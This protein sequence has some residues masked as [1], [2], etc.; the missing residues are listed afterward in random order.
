MA[1]HAPESALPLRL[2]RVVL[3][4]GGLALL[5]F[6]TLYRLGEP[7]V[8]DPN[9]GRLALGLAAIALAGLLATSAWV[10]D[11][12]LA[13]LYGFFA[14]V[15]GWQL[16]QA[17][18]S[19]LSGISALG[20]VLVFFGCSAG[21]QSV[22]WM[23][24]YTVTFVSAAAFVAARVEDPA[25]P[26]L[27]FVATL[28][29]M[30]AL[31]SYVLRARLQTLDALAEARE[32]ALATARAKSEF[33]ATM[34]H[35]IRTPMNGVIGMAALLSRSRLTP[36]QEEFVRTIQSSSEAL[37]LII[38]DVLDFSMIEA[39]RVALETE[40]IALRTFLEDTIDIIA[41]SAAGKGIELVHRIGPDV[42]GVVVGDPAR[43]RQI[44]LNLLSNAVKFTP[45]GSVVLDVDARSLGPAHTAHVELHVRVTDTGIGIRPE[46][47]ETLFH[48]FAQGDAATTRRFGGTGL[49]LAISKRLAEIMGGRMWVESERGSGSTFHFTARLGAPKA[50]ME[51]PRPSRP[52]VVLV[53]DDHEASRASIAALVEEAGFATVSAA[54]PAEALEWV[55][56]GGRPVAV[57]VDQDLGDASG[58]DL[59]QRLRAPLGPAPILLLSS[60][61]SA[62]ADP[63]R[64]DA[65]LSKPVHSARFWDT[66]LRLVDGEPL[67]T[68]AA[69]GGTAGAA[70][71]EA[72]SGEDAERPADATEQAVDGPLRVLLVEDNPANRE[73]TLT[74][75]RHLGLDADTAVDGEDALEVLAGRSY[76][77]VLM[78]VQM[79]RLDGLATTQ[80]IRADLPPEQ[81]PAVIG[82]TANALPGARQ[83]GLDAGM[84]LYL[85]KPVR[86]A[87]ISGAIASVTEGR[88][89]APDPGALPPAAVSITAD[90]VLTALDSLGGI[91]DPG[92]A[93][94]IIAAYLRADLTLTT[95]L[96][97]AAAAGDVEEVG[98]VAHKFKSSSGTLGASALAH[99]CG[100][101]ERAAREGRGPDAIRLGRQLADDLRGFRSVVLAAQGRVGE[102]SEDLA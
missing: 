91:D 6:G 98:R 44:V 16:W 47:L 21:I 29:A 48:S 46:Q 62:V 72:G 60:F 26:P 92:F 100:E 9:A 74:L 99:A 78:D 52:D 67:D 1:P 41:P 83:R 59:A 66:L 53:V 20:L 30:G 45:A 77:V 38:N 2:Y 85:T 73:V 82:L 7:H 42:P 89:R 71:A 75:L 80:R 14:V 97:A 34:S 18:A 15:S 43:L 5:G 90:R 86:S 31:G 102:P 81:Q 12:S 79:P 55:H 10:R 96:E 23:L 93:S 70:P 101:V 58:L 27:T 94:E 56:D 33:L 28:A 24:A 63:G 87:Q 37:L 39:N 36:D 68:G 3:V 11:R 50:R 8:V 88:W 22:R 51:V 69:P 32:E 57:V 61:Q 64:V 76:D 84:D 49:G 19:S 95:A 40:P 17:Y 65:V 25:L 13:F 54:S 35:E 4:M